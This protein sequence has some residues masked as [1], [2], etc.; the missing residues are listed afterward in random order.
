MLATDVKLL[1][2]NLMNYLVKIEVF[3]NE[4]NS[5]LSTLCHR[6]LMVWE[7]GVYTVGAKKSFRT[8]LKVRYKYNKNAPVSGYGAAVEEKVSLH[9]IPM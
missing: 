2:M 1:C 5:L 3:N 9:S 7:N 6:H 8:L 4:L